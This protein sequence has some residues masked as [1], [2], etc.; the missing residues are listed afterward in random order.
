M[1]AIR[2]KN[3]KIIAH[4]ID[5]YRDEHGVSPSVMDIVEKTGIP[6]SS[7]FRYLQF[8]RD[9]GVIEFTGRKGYVTTKSKKTRGQ[10]SLVPVVG[11]IACGLPKYAEGCIEEYI[12]MPVALLGSGQYYLLRANGDSMI[13]VGIEAGDLVLIRGQSYAND[14]QIVVALIDNDTA[15]LKRYYPNRKKGIVVLRA[16]NDEYEDLTINLRNHEF[17]IQGVAVKV[18]K[19]LE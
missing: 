9:D 14:G 7:V 10:T 17:L 12:P 16:E 4:A 2:E 18:I 15:T 11:S 3:Y 1:N 19:N 6:R 5:E 13:D 8:M